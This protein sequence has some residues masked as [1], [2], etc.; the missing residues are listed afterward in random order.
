MTFN[1]QQYIKFM[2]RWEL[3]K[4]LWQEGFM[5]VLVMLLIFFIG[6]VVYLYFHK[7]EHKTYDKL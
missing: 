3:L 5:L 7:E 6:V 2:A 4:P 1:P